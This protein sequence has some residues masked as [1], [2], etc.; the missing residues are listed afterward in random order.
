M[1]IISKSHISRWIVT[2][3][4]RTYDEAD[5]VYDNVTSHEVRAIATSWT[6]ATQVALDDIM[7]AAFWR[8]S[9]VFQNSYLRDLTASADGLYSLGPF[10]VA[11]QVIPTPTPHA[12]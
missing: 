7:A 12:P 6:Y 2:A 9:G 10:V 4:K 8:S 11:P 3:V 5:I 1:I